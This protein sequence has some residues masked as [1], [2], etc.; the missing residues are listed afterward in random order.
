MDVLYITLVN[1]VFGNVHQWFSV[2]IEVTG[3]KGHLSIH[4]MVK[5]HTIIPVITPIHSCHNIINNISIMSHVS[6]NIHEHI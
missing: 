2:I 1:N 3:S 6:N 5:G 4:K